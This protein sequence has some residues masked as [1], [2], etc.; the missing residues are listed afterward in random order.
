[1]EAGLPPLEHEG[2]PRFQSACCPESAAPWR[3]SPRPASVLQARLEQDVRAVGARAEEEVIDGL[4]YL[5][6]CISY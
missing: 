6:D 4:M 3:V 5:N 1:M 2:H